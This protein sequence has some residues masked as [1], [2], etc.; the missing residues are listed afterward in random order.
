MTLEKRE[1]EAVVG[2]D[3]W[4]LRRIE[5]LLVG[6]EGVAS[7][8]IVADGRGGVDEIHVLSGSELG[9]K[10][11]VRNIES[12]LLAEFGLQIDHR[13]I[14]VARVRSRSDLPAPSPVAEP[15]ATKPVRRLLLEGLHIERTAGQK[16]TCRAKLIDQGTEYAGEAE[17]PDF[18]SARMET[19]AAAVLD[20]VQQ[21]SA[22]K[23]SLALQGVSRVEIFGRSF[24][25]A[26]VNGTFRRDSI[27]LA[28][29]GKVQDSVE[30]AAVL[31]CLQALNRWIA[32]R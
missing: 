5:K 11:I 3:P 2:L 14:S 32:E 23:F 22:D 16:V 13:K 24:V 27:S 26:V 4:G 20:A 12:A 1:A 21:A 8:K 17:G 18:E 9:P 28:G 7:I 10:Q 19:A 15:V 31:A 29:I 30:E 25:I 6:L